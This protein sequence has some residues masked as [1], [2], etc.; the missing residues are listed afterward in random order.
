MSY[1]IHNQTYN[2]KVLIC[3]IT[4]MRAGRVCVGSLAVERDVAGR[5]TPLTT[6]RLNQAD[7]SFFTVHTL[8]FELNRLYEIEYIPSPRAA[9]PHT[10]DV[11]VFSWK[12]IGYL[13]PPIKD[14]ILNMLQRS[15]AIPFI[16][17]SFYDTFEGCL[18]PSQP[19]APLS[20]YYVDPKGQ[21]SSYS[22]CFW[23]TSHPLRIV[24]GPEERPFAVCPDLRLR[25]PYI[26]REPLSVEVI[27]TETLVRLALS[28]RF[29]P[30]VGKEG[31]YLML[32]RCFLE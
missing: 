11:R 32:S 16:R 10:E 7:G 24:A 27:P 3:A 30:V 22:T 20:S 6:L 17:G 15:N 31:H 1:N 23:M 28:R 4:N 14:R 18:V 21:V 8:P 9:P 2:A 12:Y 19:S 25:V 26:G 5:L 13:N 29:S